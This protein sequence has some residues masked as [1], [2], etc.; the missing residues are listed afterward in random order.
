MRFCIECGERIHL[1]A[2]FC[3]CCGSRQPAEGDFG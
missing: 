3:A 1:A 2:K